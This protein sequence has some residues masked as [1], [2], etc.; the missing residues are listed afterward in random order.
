M[1]ASVTATACG[2]LFFPSG[3]QNPAPEQNPY[4][5]YSFLAGT[6]SDRN[7]LAPDEVIPEERAVTLPEIRQKPIF[8]KIEAESCKLPDQVSIQTARAGYSDAGYI[9]TLQNM[10]TLDIPLQIHAAQHYKITICAAAPQP[11]EAVLSAGDTAC[12]DFTLDVNDFT[13][14]TCYGIFLDDGAQTLHLQCTSGALDI[15]YIEISDDTSLHDF[16]YTLDPTPCNPQASPETQKL[17]SFLCQ[18]WGKQILTGQYCADAGNQELNLIYQITGQLPAI[19]FSMLGTSDDRQQTDDAIDWSIYTNGIV[20]LMWHWNAPGSD[21][22]YADDTDFDLHNALRHKDPKKVALLTPEQAQTEYER[23][24]LSEEALLLL[25]DID[26]TAQSLT[27]LRNMHIPVLWRPLY[28]AGGGWYWWGAAGQ[29]AYVQLWELVY[30][31]LSHYH[32][33]NNLIWVWNGQSAAYLV[34]KDTY[35]IAS[36]DIYLQP[37]MQFGSRYEQFF[38]LARITEG[39]KLLGISECGSFPDPEMMQL[40]QALWSF[41]GLWCGDYLMQP[42]G[43]LNE[44]YYSSMDLYN[45]YNSKLTLSLNDFLSFYQ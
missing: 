41:F 24:I 36:V 29:D 38:A 15:D 10:Q 34:P 25:Q 26:E 45:L 6:A 42:D 16:T 8:E 11:A 31:R 7:A 19:R 1:A 9:G 23:G 30:E 28:E 12:T 4:G 32:Q 37:D 33:L 39:K 40:D 5:N 18:H 22:V 14:I 17:Y 44:S 27:R 21:S 2:F 20:G 13:R 43:S 35:D 3:I